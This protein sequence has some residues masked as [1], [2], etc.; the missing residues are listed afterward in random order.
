MRLAWRSGRDLSPVGRGKTGLLDT[1]YAAAPTRAKR[2]FHFHEFFRDLQCSA[3]SHNG[4]GHA[5]DA[6]LDDLLVGCDLLCDRAVTLT[7]LADRPLD[8]FLA[9]QDLPPDLG[10]TASRLR[11]LQS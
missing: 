4:A 11:L 2:R 1:L 10:R 9:G 3:R 7:L 6:A 5:V 8:A